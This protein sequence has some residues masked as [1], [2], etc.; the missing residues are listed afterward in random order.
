MS[1]SHR[2]TERGVFFGLLASRRLTEPS[3]PV[4]SQPAVLY[5]LHNDFSEGVSMPGK[6]KEISVYDIKDNPFKLI[7]DDWM[8]ITAG[9]MQKFNTMTASWGALGEL[10]NKKICICFV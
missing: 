1:I 4:A 8:L 2:M 5:P 3:F 6:F 10:W 9:N 7:A